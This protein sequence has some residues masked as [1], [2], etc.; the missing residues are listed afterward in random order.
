MGSD[1]RIH[2]RINQARDA[3][4]AAGKGKDGVGILDNDFQAAFDFMVL[5]WV[6]MVLKAKGLADEVINHLNNIYRNNFTVVVVNNIPG[7]KLENVRG[8]IRQGDKPS[9]TLFCY[10]IDPH[11][12]WLDKRLRGI[13]IYSM[14]AA[15][16]A[17]ENEPFPITVSEKYKVL[18]YV[19]DVK[20]AITTM[21]EFLL[22]D[23]GSHIF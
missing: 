18:G 11:L 17:L 20:P 14:P 6:I 9:S 12:V 21:A 16:P 22:V 1:R 2:H 19:N 10:G 23:H 3:I 15:G 7:K 13:P 5:P 4:T 8:S